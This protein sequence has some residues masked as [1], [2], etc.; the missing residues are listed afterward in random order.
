MICTKCLKDKECSHFYKDR[1]TSTGYYSSCRECH[2][3]GVGPGRSRLV[4]C[5]CGRKKSFNSKF[6][7]NCPLRPRKPDKYGY[8]WIS[9]DKKPILEH[10]YVMEKHLGRSLRSN[11]NVHHINGIKHDNRIENLELWV[12]TQPSGQRVQDLVTWAKE[13]LSLYSPSITTI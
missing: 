8:V 3:K 13:I 1:R 9:V 12:T 10:R 5:Y 2:I 6:C 7:K 11:E 4:D